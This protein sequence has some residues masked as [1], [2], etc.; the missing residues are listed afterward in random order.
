[1]WYCVSVLF[2]SIHTP[3]SEHERLYEE[4]LL[5]IEAADETA[6]IEVAEAR[7]RSESVE[8]DTLTGDKTRWE[9]DRVLS[10]FEIGKERPASGTEVFSR[11]L[12]KSEADSLSQ[13]LPGE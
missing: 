3:K 6:A 13:P 12:K 7:A 5:L 2:V 9:F 10:V 1:M 11:F 8:Y 4:S